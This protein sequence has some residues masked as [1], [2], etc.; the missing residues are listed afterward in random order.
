MIPFFSQ[1]ILYIGIAVARHCE[2]LIDLKRSNTCFGQDLYRAIV[3][4]HIIRFLIPGKA[5]ECAISLSLNSLIVCYVNKILDMI[6]PKSSASGTYSYHHYA[7][8]H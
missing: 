8:N 3:Y 5:S 6:Y 1:Y 2:T 4:E 7:L